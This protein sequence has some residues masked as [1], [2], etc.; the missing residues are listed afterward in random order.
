MFR[1][2]TAILLLIAFAVQLFN[3]AAIIV[4]YY[5]NTVSFAKF[6]ENKARPVMHCNGKCQMMK[7]LDAAE[8][9]DQQNPSRKV[10]NNEEVVYYQQS[11][12]NT[13]AR[14]YYTIISFPAF[15]DTSIPKGVYADIFHPPSLV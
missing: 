3:R 15:F 9:K 11:F 8:K 12:V 7:K 5:T 6:C 13:I 1:K 2:I 4:D 10:S 14:R